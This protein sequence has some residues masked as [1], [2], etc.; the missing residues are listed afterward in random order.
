MLIIA[1]K[2]GGGTQGREVKTKST[3]KKGGRRD[4]AESDS[5]DESVQSSGNKQGDNKMATLEFMSTDKIAEEL[6]KMDNVKEC[7][8]E[9]M[10]EIASQLYR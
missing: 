4:R 8:E 2:S 9:L 10:D 5:E 1:G 6:S 7:P 3:K